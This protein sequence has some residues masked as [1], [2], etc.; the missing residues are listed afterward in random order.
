MTEGN[1]VVQM[2]VASQ[3][4]MF[5]WFV[6]GTDHLAQ[7]WFW[8]RVGSSGGEA[9]I[10][11]IGTPSVVTPAVDE[12]RVSYSHASFGVEVS[13]Q[14]AG[15]VAGSGVSSINETILLTNPTATP[16]NLHFFQYSDFDLGSP[17]NDRVQLGTNS[18]GLFNFAYQYNDQISL[19]E[20]VGNAVGTVAPGAT[21]GQA[22]AFPNIL[23]SLNDANPTTLADNQNVV[24]PGDVAWA[25]QWDLTIAP[26]GS[27]TISKLKSLTVP[28]PS[29]AALLG[30]GA[31]ALAIR[32]RW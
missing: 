10:N 3:A 21:H 30:L 26:G 9:S 6:D 22:S 8:Y 5:N 14:L 13:Y 31:L 32:R 19:F 24:G 23:N 11:S 17:A 27:A 15:G 4:G 20:D 25:F 18:V 7:Q 12:V 28:E 16:L 1:S 2:N 29:S